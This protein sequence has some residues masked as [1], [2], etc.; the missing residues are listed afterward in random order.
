MREFVIKRLRRAPIIEQMWDEFERMLAARDAALTER[1]AA[2]AARDAAL[3]ERD[4]ALAA[5]DAALVETVSGISRDLAR[6]AAF[7]RLYKEARTLDMVGEAQAH[8]NAALVGIPALDHSAP[9]EAQFRNHFQPRLGKRADGFAVLFATLAERAPHPLIIETGCLR[10]PGN[11]EGDGQSSFM[12]DAFVRAKGG[13]FFSID[14]L[15]ESIE[16]ARRACSSAANL[17]CN[18]SVAA[19]YAL[20]E[21]LPGPASLVYLDSYDLDVDDPLPSAVHHALELAAVRP[22][23]GSGTLVCVD[24]YGVGSQKGGKGMIVDKFFS[25]IRAEVLFSGYQR[26]WSV[27]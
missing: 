10:V 2:L 19:L 20:S 25:S 26:I 3:T 16:T 13:H 5:R 9:P 11:W 22:L 1:D 17:I 12:F 24:D 27:R 18:D 6:S 7:E 15:P 21:L 8:G 14:R 4:A 23:I